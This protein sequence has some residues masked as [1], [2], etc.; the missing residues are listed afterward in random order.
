MTRQ[1]G[2]HS[3]KRGLVHVSPGQVFPASHV[4]HLIAEI[5]VAIRCKEMKQQNAGCN[6]PDNATRRCFCSRFRHCIIISRRESSYHTGHKAGAVALPTHVERFNF[7]GES[8]TRKHRVI[9]ARVAVSPSL[10][11]RRSGCASASLLYQVRR[12]SQNPAL[13]CFLYEGHQPQ[14]IRMGV[15][16]QR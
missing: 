11:A 5:A 9:V 12:S 14:I 8:E 10:L 2:E 16:L 15:R 3:D 6:A 7:L 13:M 4:V 1:P